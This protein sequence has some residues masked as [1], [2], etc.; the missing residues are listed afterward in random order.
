[1]RFTVNAET[2]KRLAVH[3]IEAYSG[4]VP[5]ELCSGSATNVQ[6]ADVNNPVCG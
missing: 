3:Q 5:A 2:V 1:M 4:C 6:Q